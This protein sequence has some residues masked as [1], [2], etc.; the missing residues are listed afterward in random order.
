MT[1]TKASADL[2]TGDLATLLT[3]F[4]NEELGP[5]YELVTDPVSEELSYDERV[6][7]HRPDHRAYAD[8]IAHEVRKFGGNSFANTGRGEGPPYDEIVRDVCG[9]CKVRVGKAAGLLDMERA[10]L[11]KLLD[12]LSPEEQAALRQAAAAKGHGDVSSVVPLS[13][14]ALQ[15]GGAASGFLLYQSSLQIANAMVRAVI[16]RGLSFA[17]NQM[18]A[19]TLSV[20]VGPIGWI[21][22]GAWA[23]GSLAG[24]AMRVTVPAVYHIS[25][26]RHA[27]LWQASMEVA[28]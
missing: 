12:D 1:D 21:A 22:S 17:G 10:L 13:I 4:T 3:F 27:K 26:V 8:L 23:V 9:S 25:A 16:G 24:P 7:K 6:K 15:A 20:A 28:A 2:R 5:L 19:R 11:A 18:L 14:L